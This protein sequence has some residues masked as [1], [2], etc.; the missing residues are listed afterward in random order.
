MK[1]RLPDPD[2]TRLRQRVEAA[3]QDQPDTAPGSP[4]H[5]SDRALLHELRVYQTE[6][7]TQNEELRR[8]QLERDSARARFADLYDLAPVGYCTVCETGGIIEANLTLAAM[9]G[10]VHGSLPGRPF[11]DYLLP[12]DQDSFYLLHRRMFASGAPSADPPGICELRLARAGSEPFW[13]QLVLKVDRFPGADGDGMGERSAMGIV[14]TDISARKQTEDALRLSQDEALL[15]ERRL[16]NAEALA[17][18]GSWEWNLT[19]PHSTWSD[20]LFEIYGRDPSQGVPGFDAWEETIHP[21]DRD[22]LAHCIRQA[23]A[24]ETKYSIEFRIHTR[25]TGALRY[26]SSRGVSKVDAHGKVTGIWGVDQDIT[27]VKQAAEALQASLREKDALLREVH[28]R[29]KNNLQV[30]TSLL[31]LESHRNVQPDTRNVLDEMQGRIRTMAVLHESLYHSGTFSSVDLGAYL[32]QLVAQVFRAH[33]QLGGQVRMHLDLASVQVGMDQAT[34][35][36]LIVNELVSNCLKHGFPAGHSGEVRVVLQALA[37]TPLLQLQVSDTGVGLPADFETR[38]GQSLGLQLVSDLASQ[39]D[40]RLDP[41]TG[42]GPG[43]SFTITFARGEPA[44][45]PAGD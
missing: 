26:I 44:P 32:R 21:D 24:S 16:S 27:A 37:G 15:R 43:T 42:T 30:I 8:A 35:C 39:I 11:S 31:R 25:D 12:A 17:G 40:G 38:R 5:A 2:A 18:F 7:E 20:K 13:A 9:L 10:V 22:R 4:G 23:L 34:P 6:L 28:H 3:L 41:V 19:D 14:L 36:G 45:R 29:V 33:A 1:S